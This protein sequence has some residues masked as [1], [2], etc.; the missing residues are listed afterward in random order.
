MAL[1]TTD[2]KYFSRRDRD[3]RL[4]E[5][6]A[7]FFLQMFRRHCEADPADGDSLLGRKLLAHH[8]DDFPALKA[9]L[10][11]ADPQVILASVSHMH[12]ATREV[13]A[14]RVRTVAPRPWR[15][16]ACAASDRSLR[17]SSRRPSPAMWCY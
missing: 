16:A 15:V 12:S 11:E 1:L 2:C 8:P 5:I 4:F 9:A 14:V 17:M 10:A 6:G 13:E 3:G 7:V